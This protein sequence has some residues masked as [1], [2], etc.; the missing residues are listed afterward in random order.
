MVVTQTCAREETST[1]MNAK[2]TW[3][4]TAVLTCPLEQN[5][6]AVRSGRV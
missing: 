4:Y 3:F 1:V 2:T 6:E 5:V